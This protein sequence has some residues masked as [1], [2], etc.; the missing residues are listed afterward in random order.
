MEKSTQFEA[1]NRKITANL[2]ING[3]LHFFKK[4]NPW[5][6]FKAKGEDNVLS[7]IYSK[8][9]ENYAS[10][11]QQAWLKI[12]SHPFRSSRHALYKIRSESN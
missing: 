7:L 5:A 2:E 10:S 11:Y 4:V 6:K 3:E 12:Y 1:N 8:F 9:H